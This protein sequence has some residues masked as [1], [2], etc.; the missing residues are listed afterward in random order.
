MSDEIRRE[1]VE[2]LKEQD[3]KI[4][5]LEIA[6]EKERRMVDRLEAENLKLRG[7]QGN[8]DHV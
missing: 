7:E 2:E 3:E 5:V 6:L 8:D 1:E 4:R